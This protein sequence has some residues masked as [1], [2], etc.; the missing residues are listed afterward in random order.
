MAFTNKQTVEFWSMQEHD[1]TVE[2]KAGGGNIFSEGPVIYSYGHHFPMAKLLPYKHALLTTQGYSA[3]TSNHLGYVAYALRNHTVFRVYNASADCEIEHIGNLRDYMERY[4][5]LQ[6]QYSRARSRKPEIAG[7]MVDLIT[8]AHNY[9]EFFGMDDTPSV[10]E[11]LGIPDEAE[12]QRKASNEL[13]QQGR[14]LR[15]RPAMEV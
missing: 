4:E 15:V 3:T 5:E 9:A 2:F 8:E 12:M 7:L 1:C 11:I 13:S 6:D 14:R 10:R